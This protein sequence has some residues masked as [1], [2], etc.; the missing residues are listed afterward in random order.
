MIGTCLRSGCDNVFNMDSKENRGTC[1]K[2]CRSVTRG[3]FKKKPMRK[4]RLELGYA[5]ACRTSEIIKLKKAKL[6]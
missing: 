1:S 2:L 4:A 3:S 5:N 6:A